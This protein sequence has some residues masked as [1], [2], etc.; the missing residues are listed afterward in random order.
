LKVVGVQG[1]HVVK[2]YEGSVGIKA[3]ISVTELSKR[4][5]PTGCNA[6]IDE[7][8]LLQIPYLSYVNPISGTLSL[9][10]ELLYEFNPTYPTLILFKLSDA[11]I[12]TSPSYLCEASTLSYDFKIHIPDVLLPDGSTH[13]WV[14]LEYD[15]VTSTE[16]SAYFLVTNYGF[17]FGI[18]YANPNLYL[19]PGEQSDL[20]DEY[21]NIVSSETGVPINNP[22]MA[23]LTKIFQ[24]YI[25]HF[26]SY[27]G[28][29]ALIGKV[30]ANQIFE[31]HLISGCHDASLI[32]SSLLRKFGFP[33]VMIDT[34]SIQW[35]FDYHNGLTQSFVGHVLSEIYVDSKWILL[36]TNGAYISNYNPYNPYIPPL[37]PGYSPTPIG[38][39]VMLKGIDTW[40]YGI[41]SPDDL[42]VVMI[43]FADKVK[44]TC[45]ILSDPGYHWVFMP[46]SHK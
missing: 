35:A 17:V 18:D 6:T 7:R 26:T 16:G 38:L 2:L 10:A 42:R 11:G 5:T 25:D 46:L 36:D 1:S 43:D 8:L 22:T 44:S 14:D 31:T 27:A 21:V 20:K 41:R 13:L 3:S 24:W 32:I 15:S 34:A 19:C 33:A 9:W 37:N 23:N 29:G 45:S 30:T 39:Y 12:I 40:G 28:G 4:S